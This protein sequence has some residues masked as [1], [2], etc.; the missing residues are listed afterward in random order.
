GFRE[1]LRETFTRTYA[2][3]TKDWK[4]RRNGENPG[5]LFQEVNAVK[6][7]T[8]EQK[9]REEAR[10]FGNNCF[11]RLAKHRYFEWTTMVVILMNAMHIGV[12]IMSRTLSSKSVGHAT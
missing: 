4:D 2:S 8:P 3:W 10:K 1:A 7:K 11:G 9:R 6:A 12:V 5:A